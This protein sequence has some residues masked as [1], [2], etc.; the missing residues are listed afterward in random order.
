LL[1]KNEERLTDGLLSE[2]KL[3]GSI[4]SILKTKAPIHAIQKRL[5]SA[6]KDCSRPEKTVLG[7]KRLFSAG[8]D[9]SAFLTIIAAERIKLLDLCQ[10]IEKNEKFSSRPGR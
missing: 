1:A 10:E 3:T 6:G 2:N 8:K 5:F 9:C 7:R 4:F